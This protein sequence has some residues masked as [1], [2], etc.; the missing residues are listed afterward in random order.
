MLAVLEVEEG[1]DMGESEEERTD[2]FVESEEVSQHT[3]RN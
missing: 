1:R 2:W 3:H